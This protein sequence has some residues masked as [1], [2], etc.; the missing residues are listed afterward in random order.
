MAVGDFHQ[1]ASG[2]SFIETDSGPNIWTTCYLCGA[3]A[4]C[5]LAMKVSDVR[6]GTCNARQYEML[7]GQRMYELKEAFF[8]DYP[9]LIDRIRILT[10]GAFTGGHQGAG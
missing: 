3:A 6:C 9:K 2:Y 4:A 10:S 5:H 7:P 8:R 1:Y